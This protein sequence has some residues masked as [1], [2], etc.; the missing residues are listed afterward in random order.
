M[1]KRGR[2]CT[3]RGS[4]HPQFNRSSWLSGCPSRLFR[5]YADCSRTSITLSRSISFRLLSSLCQ[6]RVAPR[7]FNMLLLELYAGAAAIMALA[8]TFG[9]VARTVSR[10]TRE[11][12][13]RI[14]V[15]AR[16]AAVAF[17]IVRQAMVYVLFGIGVGRNRDVRCWSHHAR[18]AL[19][20]PTPGSG[21]Y[22]ADRC[23][24]GG[25]RLRGLLFAGGQSG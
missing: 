23:R 24:S 21:N 11:T 20:S 13:V 17:M 4:G 14:A 15:G 2:N 6:T 19:W 25:R 22:H 3:I 18:H 16:P 1:A 8:G 10:R 7:R 12:A 9:V 5:T